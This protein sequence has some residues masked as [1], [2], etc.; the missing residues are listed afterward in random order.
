LLSRAEAQRIARLWTGDA[1]P[2][3]PAAPLFA[4]AT[5]GRVSTGVHRMQLALHLLADLFP[6]VFDRLERDPYNPLAQ[7]ELA[8]LRRLHHYLLHA[9]IEPGKPSCRIRGR[10]A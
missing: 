7:A 2:D 5:T 8:D 10:A 6:L 3:D 4:F 1:M 9:P